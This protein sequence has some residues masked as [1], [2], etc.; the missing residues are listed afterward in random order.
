MYIVK[1]ET[2]KYEFTDKVYADGLAKT[3]GGTV[4]Y[5][6]ICGD[7]NCHCESPCKS[8]K[9]LPNGFSAAKHDFDTASERFKILG[10]E[11]DDY[12]LNN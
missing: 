8:F 5:K 7:P 2:R 3:W 12:Q 4:E 6:S 11:Q 9:Y 1:F 10:H